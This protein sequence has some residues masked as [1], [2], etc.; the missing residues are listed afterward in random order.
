MARWN[1]WEW[2]FGMPGSTG[3]TASAPVAARGAGVTRVR[4]PASSHS[5]STSRAQPRG[6]NASEAKRCIC[7]L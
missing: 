5:I 7:S 4:V 2:T 6:S 1:A 3:P